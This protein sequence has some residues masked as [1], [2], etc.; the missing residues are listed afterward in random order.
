[1]GLLKHLSISI[2]ES[3]LCDFPTAGPC[4]SFRWLFQPLSS[5]MKLGYIICAVLC[6]TMP[7]RAC[8]LVWP[9]ESCV[10]EQIPVLPVLLT[11]AMADSSFQTPESVLLS[12]GMTWSCRWLLCGFFSLLPISSSFLPPSNPLTLDKR[13]KR[14]ERKEIPKYSQGLK[15]GVILS[16]DYFLLFRGAEFLGASLNFAPVDLTSSHCSFFVRVY[17][18]SCNQQ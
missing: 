17:L 1:M 14:I 16:L 3:C 4:C 10:L 18:I 8:S 11:G 13:E 2:A 9:Q 15:K 6:L 7:C 5:F 12:A